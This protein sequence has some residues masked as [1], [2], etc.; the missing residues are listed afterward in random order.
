MDAAAFDYTT[1]LLTPKS[2]GDINLNRNWLEHPA[3]RTEVEALIRFIATVRSIALSSD[4]LKA[5][6]FQRELD[7]DWDEQPATRHETE[8]LMRVV[9]AIHDIVLSPAEDY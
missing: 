4:E 1:A 5:N 9:A 8:A 2:A 6:D 3:T 7:R